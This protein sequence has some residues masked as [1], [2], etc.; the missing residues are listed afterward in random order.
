M[1]RPIIETYKNAKKPLNLHL[2]QGKS[3]YYVVNFYRNGLMFGAVFL[4]GLSS[5]HS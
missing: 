1:L 3:I 5:I 4:M 2:G